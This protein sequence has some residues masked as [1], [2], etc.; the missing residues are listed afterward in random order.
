MCVILF[1]DCRTQWTL[2]CISSDNSG[3]YVME[4]T[5]NDFPLSTDDQAQNALFCGKADTLLLFNLHINGFN[6]LQKRNG[7][8]SRLW[9]QT[10]SSVSLCFTNT[11]LIFQVSRNMLGKPKICSVSKFEIVNKLSSLKLRSNA[12]R[13]RSFSYQYYLSYAHTVH[14]HAHKVKYYDVSRHVKNSAIKID[15]MTFPLSRPL[16][17]WPRDWRRSHRSPLHRLLAEESPVRTEVKDVP[18][19][20]VVYVCWRIIYDQRQLVCSPW[21]LFIYFPKE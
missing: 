3:G 5:V 8:K 7:L 15:P 2:G 17:R 6:F 11:W 4:P 12:M 21:M 14:V 1:T 16:L 13:C 10:S 19:L 20:R 9:W 18:H